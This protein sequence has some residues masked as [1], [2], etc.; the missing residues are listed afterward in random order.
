[1]QTKK[2]PA[3]L[4]LDAVPPSSLSALL[5]DHFGVYDAIRKPRRSLIGLLLVLFAGPSL[6]AV[7]P[8]PP[9][10]AA[11]LLGQN[12]NALPCKAFF[13]DKSGNYKPKPLFHCSAF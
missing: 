13:L 2:A 1:V 4:E 6:A 5:A 3:L 8:A 10:D 11:Y 7:S 9:N 12:Y